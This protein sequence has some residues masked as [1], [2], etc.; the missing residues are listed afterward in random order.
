MKVKAINIFLVISTT[1]SLHCKQSQILQ[2][3]NFQD[4]RSSK[5]ETF[6]V[7]FKGERFNQIIAIIRDNDKIHS[8]YNISTK[9]GCVGK[10]E[11]TPGIKRYALSSSNSF[12]VPLN[13]TDK[14]VFK[15][16]ASLPQIE[17][18]CSKSLLDSAKGFNSN[19]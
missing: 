1:V 5:I 8:T 18:Y 17:T 19:R 14:L 11:Y 4:G 6:T 13:E 7:K 15:K 2:Q 9:C 10:S 3:E 16:F 12:E